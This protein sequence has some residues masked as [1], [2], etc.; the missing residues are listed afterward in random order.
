MAF[1][2]LKNLFSGQ[3]IREKYERYER[4]LSSGALLLGFIIDNLTLRRIDRLFENLVLFTYLFLAAFGIIFLNIVEARNA[5]ENEYSRLHTILL[6]LIQFSFGALF[7]AF[8]IF[9]IRSSSLT[10]SWPFIL[11][12]L[13]LLVGN[14]ILKKRYLRL[15]F[16]V[17]VFFVTLFSFAIFYVP[18]I[19]GSLGV[20]VFLGSGVVSLVLIGVFLYVLSQAVPLKFKESRRYFVWGIGGFYIALNLFY[21]AN[22]IPPIPLSLKDAE[23]FHHVMRNETGEYVV[24]D[25]KDSWYERFVFFDRI[26]LL[27]GN[28]LYVFSA[29]FAPTRLNT[30]IVHKWQYFDYKISRWVTQSTIEFP[31]VG[32]EDGGY[33]GYSMKTNL[34][35][36]DWR[37]NIQTTHGQTIGR[38]KFKIIEVDTKSQVE[39]KVL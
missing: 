35:P 7:S 6:L 8:F 20:W 10:A 16:Q 12:L 37:V 34:T 25:E 11:L 17:T 5:R 3:S 9:Y 4:H 32:G 36:G 26:H 27:K 33:R 21:F 14:E 2:K 13:G 15:S 38:V 19:V 1:E 28:P 22:I 31:I 23:V 30:E 29:V 24:Q 39:T 18:I